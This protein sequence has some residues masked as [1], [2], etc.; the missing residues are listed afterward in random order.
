MKK[1]FKNISKKTLYVI[2][3]GKVEAGEIVKVDEGFHN[4]NF[5][6]VK[7]KS[8]EPAQTETSGKESTEEK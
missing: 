4:A 3:V 7:S 8:K 5:E 6:E 1:Q 2:G